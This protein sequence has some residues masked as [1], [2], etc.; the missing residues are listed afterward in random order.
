MAFRL[1]AA[2]RRSIIAGPETTRSAPAFFAF[3]LFCFTSAALFF[4]VLASGIPDAPAQSARTEKVILERGIESL[5]IGR[6][7]YLTGDSDNTLTYKAVAQ[8]HEHNLLGERSEQDVI[9]L[10]PDFSPVWL[11]FSVTNNS[12][13]ENWVLH[14]GSVSAGRYAL[15]R[16]VSVYNYTTGQIFA[17]PDRPAPKNEAMKAAAFSPGFAQNL[18][19]PVRIRANATDLFIVSLIPEQSFPGTIAPVLMTYSR[20]MN[21]HASGGGPFAVFQF[22]LLTGA[23]AFFLA[24][25]L[26]KGRL[27]YIVFS[28]YYLLNLVALFM[29]GRF[30]LTDIFWIKH[31]IAVLQAGI[32]LAGL[33][34]AHVF[35][36][37]K[38]ENRGGNILFFILGGTVLPGLLSS[39]V[40]QAVPALSAFFYLLPFLVIPAGLACL[41]MLYARGGRRDALLYGAG[42]GVIF[43][44]VAVMAASVAGWF[45]ANLL[46]MNAYWLALVPQAVLFMAGAIGEVRT[47]EEADHYT[48]AREDRVAQSLERLKQSKESADQARLL[49]VIERERELMAELREREMQRTEEMRQ[50]KDMADEAN[51]AKSAFLAVVSHEIRTPM[52]GILG[53]IRLL[54]DTKMTKQQHEYATAIQKS[55]ETMMAL[56]NDIL[57]FEKIESGKMELEYIDFNLPRLAQGVVTLMSGHAAEKGVTLK[58]DIADN[59][60]KI[61]EG[62]PT[63]L[64]QVLLNLVSNAIKFTE[65]GGEVKL[66]IRATLL[67]EKPKGVKG[68]Y[69]IYFAVKDSGI[70]MSEEVQSRLFKPFAQ[71]DKSTARKYGGTGL[72]LTICRRLLEVMGS[73]IEVESKEGEGSTFF[74]KLPLEIGRNEEVTEE[75]ASKAAS[76]EK[77]GVPPLNILVIE[78]NEMNRK[79]L[80]GFLTKGRHNVTLT[81]SGESGLNICRHKAFD[82]ILSDLNLS[83]MS[84]LETTKTLRMTPDKKIA[85]TPVIALTGNVSEEDVQRCYAANMNGF[86]AKPIDPEKLDEILWKVHKGEL[87]QPVIVQGGSSTIP[88]GGTFTEGLGEEALG[89][90]DF[91]SFEEAANMFAKPGAVP[92]KAPE[93]K[94]LFDGGMLNGLLDTLGKEALEELMEGFW[95]KASDIVT[96]IEKSAESDDRDALHAHAHE[97]KGM[98]AN[99][100]LSVLSDLGAGIERA[101]K[102][103]YESASIAGDIGKLRP[104][105]EESLQAVQD[106]IAGR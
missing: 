8:R 33:Y 26:I 50:A 47:S 1:K 92:E 6:R 90:D 28:A 12:D 45:P 81:D 80:L 101:T 59:F 37:I 58:M 84:G 56:L 69:E 67:V 89:G 35:L 94:P 14:F 66:I 21:M 54:L 68:D 75:E 96:D 82:V 103:E 15:V 73:R 78:D 74:F 63:R 53:M 62:D 29:L 104:C 98:A 93:I 39:F 91:D 79:V 27:S 23:A 34:S 87:D 4:L 2:Q 30:F 10:G 36:G 19:V 95:A 105:Y 18:A 11:V 17:R 61:F 7:I 106:W 16:E 31:I 22:V 40:F 46:T 42:W 60:P 24:V 49:R 70:G 20:Y 83:G 38:A 43:A 77:Q 100:G 99:F 97:L 64:R 71:A 5:P 9:A 85:S 44:G 13:T 41:S 72:G 25:S 3:F 52:T 57:D 76:G 102:N 48:R 88:S 32:L 65:R 86:L 55:G 51:R